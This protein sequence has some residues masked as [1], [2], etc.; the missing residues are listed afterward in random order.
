MSFLGVEQSLTGRCWLGPA[1]EVERAAEAMSQQTP[2]PPAVCQVLARRGVPTMEAQGF[3]TPQLKDLLPDPRRMKDMDRA[4]ARFLQAVQRRERIAVFADYDVDGGS[5]A[6][7]LL[8]WLRDMGLP[9]TL[10]VPDRID[11]G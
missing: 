3:L 9:A 5:S 10:Y 1:V 8:V 11:E 4:A 2:L 7:L 6:A